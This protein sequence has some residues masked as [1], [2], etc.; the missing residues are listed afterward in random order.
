MGGS[1]THQG[2]YDA[3]NSDMSK[4]SHSAYF[5]L[6]G[7]YKEN[8]VSIGFSAVYRHLLEILGHVPTNEGGLLYT[9]E[10]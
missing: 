7:M 4:I 1:Q 10:S 2:L 3:G 6:K 8:I 5:K 9:R